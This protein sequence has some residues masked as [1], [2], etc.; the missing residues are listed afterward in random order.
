ML[1]TLLFYRALLTQYLKTP[2]KFTSLVCTMNRQQ[3]YEIEAEEVDIFG[4]LRE[5]ALSDVLLSVIPNSQKNVIDV[6]CGDGY[7]LYCIK[8]L[9]K[10]N[11]LFGIDLS[12]KR[13]KKTRTNVSLAKC[14]QGE[15]RN[16]PFH[17]NCFDVV[18]CSET[19][20]HIEKC[21]LAISEL[22]RITRKFLIV[23]VPNEETLI[24]DRCPKCNHHFYI[25]DHKNSFDDKKLK[26]LL[27]SDS[28]LLLNRVVKFRT[29]F[30]YNRLT[31]KWPRQLRFLLDQ[32]LVFFS[33]WLPFFKPSYLLIAVQK[34]K[35]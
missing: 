21:N 8:K 32:T 24:I 14:I 16:L 25:N 30:S 1:A 19:L 34:R 20:E 3:Y 5:M 29:I 11:N 13:L 15:I 35:T 7:L 22:V 26:S 9:K 18:I 27:L 6:G 28:S 23:T 31:I 2:T 4:E 33:R 17:D 10:S 12:F